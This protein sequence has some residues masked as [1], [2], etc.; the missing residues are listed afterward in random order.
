MIRYWVGGE[1]LD[2]GSV[3]SAAIT[4]VSSCYLQ[5]EA[6]VVRI[7]RF[8]KSEHLNSTRLPMGIMKAKNECI[9]L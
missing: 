2:T 9:C 1:M 4:L 3:R 8:Y 6:I 5:S 7:S